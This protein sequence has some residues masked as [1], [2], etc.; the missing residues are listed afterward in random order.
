MENVTA[1]AFNWEYFTEQNI[2]RKI[3]VRCTLIFQYATIHQRMYVEL[4]LLMLRDDKSETLPVG[5][6]TT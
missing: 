2:A 6:P 5:L 3:T 1:T 4:V